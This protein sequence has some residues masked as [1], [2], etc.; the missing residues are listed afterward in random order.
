MQ[1]VAQVGYTVEVHQVVLAVVDDGHDG[2]AIAGGEAAEQ[3][4][5]LRMH[6][7]PPHHLI[8]LSQVGTFGKFGVGSL[9]EV[10][11]YVVSGRCVIGQLVK[12]LAVVRGA[13]HQY[14]MLHV[15]AVAPV[16]LYQSTEHESPHTDGH[17][18]NE[19]I[20]QVEYVD[21]VEVFARHEHHCREQGEKEHVFEYGHH[22]LESVHL[23]AVQ[24]H[25]PTDV[26]YQVAQKEGDQDLGEVVG[27]RG[28]AAVQLCP[29]VEQVEYSSANEYVAQQYTGD[30][31]TVEVYVR[32]LHG[33]VCFFNTGC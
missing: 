5:H 6:A 24:N 14:H 13:S 4:V 2:L 15:P 32:I 11:Q 9:V 23:G 26:A 19:H 33:S 3:V 28:A 18:G 20:G 29:P 21:G 10:A 8:G 17:E 31:G 1:V 22:N 7:Q 12:Q 16:F 30:D 25:A 27:Q